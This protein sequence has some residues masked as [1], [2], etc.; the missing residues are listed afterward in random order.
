MQDPIMYGLNKRNMKLLML[1]HLS[2]SYQNVSPC[3]YH[4]LS[5]IIYDMIIIRR[6]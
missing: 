4:T 1:K 3:N 2:K 6:F 5:S